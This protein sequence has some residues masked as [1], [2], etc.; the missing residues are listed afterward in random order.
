MKL[1]II[2]IKNKYT[3]QEIVLVNPNE[4]WRKTE[5][6]K[7]GELK[8]ELLTYDQ[9]LERYDLDENQKQSLKNTMK[10]WKI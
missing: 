7:S 6:I 8:E 1:P 9:I 10:K 2:H 5:Q 3:R 4:N